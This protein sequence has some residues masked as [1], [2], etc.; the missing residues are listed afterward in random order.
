MNTMNNVNNR[1]YHTSTAALSTS[2][3]SSD[4]ESGDLAL[5]STPTFAYT[6]NS[7]KNTDTVSND[8]NG[9]CYVPTATLP[10]PG[11]PDAFE[12]N[13]GEWSCP[14]SPIGTMNS[15]DS[16]DTWTSGEKGNCRAPTAAPALI[17]SL[18]PFHPG[19]VDSYSTWSNSNAAELEGNISY[20]APRLATTR[21]P[22]AFEPSGIDLSYTVS[23]DNVLNS[24]GDM[25]A[26]ESRRKQALNVPTSPPVAKGYANAL[27]ASGIG[28]SSTPA[29]TN[30]V[31]SSQMVDRVKSSK[32]FNG[33]SPA[34]EPPTAGYLKAVP[35]DGIDLSY[36]PG[37]TSKVELAKSGNKGTYHSLTH[38]SALPDYTSTAKSGK[39]D[40]CPARTIT[41]S[42]RNGRYGVVTADPGIEAYPS[43]FES[44]GNGSRSKLIAASWEEHIDERTNRK[45]FYNN[46]TGRV[47]ASC[48]WRYT[49]SWHGKA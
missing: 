2:A 40:I 12:S 48:L 38:A 37:D 11:Y 28:K 31:T 27:Q 23:D 6:M 9:K 26:V 15:S 21:Y 36:T 7:W 19:G 49:R 35:S 4:I 5:R 22:S 47:S 39:I 20:Y 44:S 43:N 34:P 25:N 46:I 13:G 18:K 30:A 3:Y 33:P 17:A 42:T 10:T 16:T 14:P 8:K 29:Y 24:I 45:Y 32:N 1:N 41:N